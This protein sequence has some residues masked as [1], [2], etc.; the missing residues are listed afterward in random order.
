[1][2][3]TKVETKKSGKKAY[4]ILSSVVALGLVSYAATTAIYGNQE[5]TDDAQIDADTVPVASRIPGQVAHI[6][7]HDNQVV[8]KGELIAELDPTD[9]EIRVM[10]AEADLEAAVAQAEVASKDNPKSKSKSKS[11]SNSN[12]VAQVEVAKANNDRAT[13]E[14]QK[15]Q[16]DFIRAKELKQQNAISAVEFE[17][18]QNN[19]D[20]AR[21][22]FEQSSAQ[23]KI[24]H[25]Q[26]GVAQ[27]KVKAA[28]ANLAQAQTQLKYTK[29]YAPRDGMLSRI[30]VQEGQQIQPGQV[31]AQVV[32]QEHYVIANFKENQVGRMK[33]GQKAHFKI[34]SFPGI[35]FEGEIESISPATGARFSLI[36]PDN[37]SGNFVKVVQR[38]P[39]KIKWSGDH[40]GSAPRAGLSVEATVLLK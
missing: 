20:K 28:E 8:K 15:A 13:A 40:Q 35:D 19:V 11:K 1:M 36:P 31:F 34:D 32:S 38:V 2:G 18:F 25:E 30:A 24:A 10:Q 21:A 39:V 4:I 9:Y 5:T 22:T 33:I 3:D 14:L 27:A 26:H 6:D 12:N 37:A 17:T 7:A 16:N 29:I 23:I